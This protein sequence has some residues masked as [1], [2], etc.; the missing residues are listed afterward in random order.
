MQHLQG[1]ICFIEDTNVYIS[2]ISFIS[3][4][5]IFPY[6]ANSYIILKIFTIWCLWIALDFSFKLFPPKYKVTPIAF[7][8][9]FLLLYLHLPL[10][11]E[12]NG[13]HNF[14]FSIFDYF[15][16]CSTDHVTSWQ[17]CDGQAMAFSCVNKITRLLRFLYNPKERSFIGKLFF[18]R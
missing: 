10:V 2:N 13:I 3:D 17:R 15:P 1:D 18:N 11:V 9:A 6:N 16:Y 7:S 5:M 4:I 8:L 12:V 14:F